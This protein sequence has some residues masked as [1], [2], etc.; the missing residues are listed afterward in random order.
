[1][2]AKLEQRV[3]MKFLRSEDI[4]PVEIQEDVDGLDCF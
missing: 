2:N 3:I 4:D 1:M